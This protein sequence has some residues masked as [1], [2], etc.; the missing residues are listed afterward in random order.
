MVTQKV[1]V[2]QKKII[3]AIKEN[4]NITQEKLAEIIGDYV[5]QLCSNASIEKLKDIQ[6][7]YSLIL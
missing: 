7:T 1:T 3:K 5:E 2:N 6:N 4:P